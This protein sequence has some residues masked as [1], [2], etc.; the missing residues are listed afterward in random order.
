VGRPGHKIV[1]AGA[2]NLH[3]RVIGVNSWLRH[4]L[5]EPFLQST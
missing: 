3:F 2:V 1:S 5:D 4:D